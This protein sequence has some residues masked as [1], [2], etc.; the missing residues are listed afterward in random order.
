MTCVNMCQHDSSMIIFFKFGIQSFYQKMACH[1]TTK[2]SKTIYKMDRSI[3]S[4][5]EDNNETIK[6]FLRTSVSCY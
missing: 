3:P 1:K 2:L 4:T 6:A 5:F